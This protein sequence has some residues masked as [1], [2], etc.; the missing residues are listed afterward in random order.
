MLADLQRE[1]AERKRINDQHVTLQAELAQERRRVQAL[2]GVTPVSPE[3]AEAEEVRN[4][5]SQVIT[6]DVLLKQLGLS[7]EEIADFKAMRAERSQLQETTN[8][9]WQTHGRQMI[10]AVTAELSTVYGGDLTK[11]QTDQLTKAYVLR[12]Q[13]DPEFLQRHEQGDPELAKEFAKEWAEDWFEPAR[14]RVTATEVNSFRP[15]PNGKDR[16]LVNNGEK[17]IDVN[18][19]TQVEDVLVAGF[20]ARGNKFRK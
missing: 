20:R 9:Y 15:V 11:R 16:H 10:K 4:R 1:R 18:D 5:F 8:H 14:R 6:S 2:S 13:T 17:K 3:D 12:A 19:P 7:K